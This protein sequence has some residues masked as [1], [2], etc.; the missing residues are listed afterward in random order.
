MNDSIELIK[1]DATKFVEQYWNCEN[2]YNCIDCP[3]KI[4]GKTPYEHYE[5]FICSSA[6]QLEL[7]ERTVKV[8]KNR[9]ERTCHMELRKHGANYD[10]FYFD[11]CDEEFAENINDQYS[12]RISCDVCPYCGAKVVE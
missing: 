3:S 5:T 2:A 9:A 7:I 6:M 1:E 11:C 4:D 10:V 12:S 8:M